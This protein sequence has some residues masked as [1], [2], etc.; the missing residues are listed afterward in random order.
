MTASKNSE[1]WLVMRIDSLAETG[2][3]PADVLAAIKN[4]RPTAPLAWARENDFAS[5]M[6][7]VEQEAY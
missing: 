1:V 6:R 7:Q 3:V 4:Q 5:A 2:G